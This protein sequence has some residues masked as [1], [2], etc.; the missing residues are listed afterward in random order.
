M[1]L[2]RVACLFQRV[3]RHP[4]R[5]SQVP[6]EDNFVEEAHMRKLSYESR[7]VKVPFSSVFLGL[8]LNFKNTMTR[9]KLRGHLTSTKI[10]VLVHF[11]GDLTCLKWNVSSFQ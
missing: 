7:D 8:K 2:A 10:L 6:H 4:L 11:L 5:A 9:S 3:W 1:Q